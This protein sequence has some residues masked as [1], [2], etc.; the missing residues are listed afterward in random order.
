MAEARRS[1][2]QSQLQDSDAPFGF[3]TVRQGSPHKL[4][5]SKPLDL[6]AQR[7]ARRAAWAVDSAA[8]AQWRRDPGSRRAR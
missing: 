3:E 5:I 2:V 1:H 4:V 6:H 8:L 7:S